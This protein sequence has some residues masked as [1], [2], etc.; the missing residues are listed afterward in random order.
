[1]DD[2]LS[3]PRFRCREPQLQ[4]LDRFLLLMEDTKIRPSKSSY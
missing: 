1:V 3:A 2:Q 4:A